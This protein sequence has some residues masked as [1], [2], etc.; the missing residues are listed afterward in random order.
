MAQLNVSLSVI[1]LCIS[2]LNTPI[3]RQRSAEV[4]KRHDSTK[5]DLQ[6][7]NFRFKDKTRWKVKGQK[8]LQAITSQKESLG[9]CK[10]EFKFLK[11]YRIIKRVLYIDKRDNPQKI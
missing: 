1:I 4:I 11:N 2:G 3:K 10:M 6:E 8:T 7:T 9:G 5:G